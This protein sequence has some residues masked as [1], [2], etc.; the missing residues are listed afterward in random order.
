MRAKCEHLVRESLSLLRDRMTVIIIAHRLSTLQM[1]DRIMVIQDGE[2]RGFDSR[3]RLE[4]SS[5]FF[6]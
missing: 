1:C 5:E 3:E 6:C 4:E 2:L